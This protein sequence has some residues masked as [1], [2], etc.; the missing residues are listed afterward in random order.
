MENVIKRAFGEL[1]N[2]FRDEFNEIL[3]QKST[4]VRFFSSHNWIKRI[5]LK[6]K[7]PNHTYLAM[8]WNFC[9]GWRHD[10]NIIMYSAIY[11]VMKSY[12]TRV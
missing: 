3:S 8:F 5:K 9:V 10:V 6:N 12:L 11:G 1:N 2:I 4:N 7:N